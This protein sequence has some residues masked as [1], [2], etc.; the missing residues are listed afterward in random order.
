MLDDDSGS[1]LDAGLETYPAAAGGPPSSSRYRA[2][3]D[4][5]R[6]PDG[7][8]SLTRRHVEGDSGEPLRH[9]V[10]MPDYATG[11]V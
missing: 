4:M 10:E 3:L 6:D 1:P 7:E 9:P 11:S 8:Y 5:I 2:M